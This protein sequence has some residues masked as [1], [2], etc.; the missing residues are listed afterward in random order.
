MTSGPNS[1][2]RM[3]L[4]ASLAWV[5]SRQTAL[6]QEL[7][8]LNRAS[9]VF[10]RALAILDQPAGFVDQPAARHDGCQPQPRAEGD[11]SASGPD[12][13]DLY[14][15]VD[16]SGCSNDRERILRIAET[17]DGTVRLKDATDAIYALGFAKGKKTSLRSNLGRILSDVGERLETGVYRVD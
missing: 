10:H 17:T 5:S 6:L 16:F 15:G 13:P 11:Q 14:T 8:A 1:E 7:A 4:L 2:L 12:T 9:S 3:D